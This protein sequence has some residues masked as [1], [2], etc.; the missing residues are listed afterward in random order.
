VYSGTTMT[1]TFTVS[2][3]E[4]QTITVAPQSTVGGNSVV[5]T[6]TMSLPAPPAGAPVSLASSSVNAIVP[7]VV[8][9]ASGATSQSFEIDTTDSVGTQAVITATYSGQVRTTTLTIAR[10]GLQS[11]SVGAG[12]VPGG[13]TFPGFVTMSVAASASGATVALSSSSP[14]ATVPATVTVPP[15]AT[16]AAFQVTTIDQPPTE[17]VTISATYAGVTDTA[18]LTIL[19]F[20]VVTSMTC[21]PNTPS[22]GAA[23]QCLGALQNPAPSAGWTLAVSSSDPSASVP[24]VI[25]VPASAAGFQFPVSTSVVTVATPVSLQVSDA[26]SGLALYTISITV[27]P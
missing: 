7:P 8:T 11:V 25:T 15:G 24:A 22:G 27:S 20:P 1:A 6:L 4:L 26:A 3:P 10:E 2:R 14:R 16:T 23:V 9:I 18:P 13:S 19:A 5:G 17:T 12:P 21:T